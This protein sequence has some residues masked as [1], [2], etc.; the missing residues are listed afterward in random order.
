MRRKNGPVIAYVGRILPSLSETFIVREIAALRKLGL[1]IKP[2]SIHP[3]DPEVIHP[4]APE[5]SSEVEVLTCPA[6]PQ[7][8]LAHI[9][10]ALAMPHRYFSCLWKY[11]LTGERT[12]DLR[13][14]C[15]KFF[16][17]A[18]LLALRVRK[19]E[20]THIH[21]HFANVSTAVSM[22][23]AALAGISFSF[24]IHTN[25]EMIIDGI[26]MNRKLAAARF[27]VTISRFNIT[28]YLLP[29]FKATDL[30]KIHIVRCGI[31]CD[32]YI[33]ESHSQHNPPL[34][35][36]VGRLADNKGFH[37]LVSAC[38]ILKEMG[39]ETRCEIIG[40]G[41]ERANLE[42]QISE[43]GLSGAVTL[44]GQFL[45]EH[46]RNSL[47]RADLFALPCCYGKSEEEKGN[48]DGIP[49]ALMEAM[50]MGIPTISTRI[51]GIP[52][53]IL[54][55]QTG[56]L[57]SHEDPEALAHAMVRIIQDRDLAERL[58]SGGREIVEREFNIY[59]SASRLFDLF[60]RDTVRN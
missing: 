15:F 6:N 31:D 21:A 19:T 48:H 27:V 60:M 39:V 52:E 53:L 23:A 30:S 36:S 54:D 51:G 58:S 13:L 18:P 37:T 7:F 44:V 59:R 2:F 25:Y 57:V 45:A 5:L 20:V 4:E 55:E 49:V 12:W 35:L 46:V 28:H 38:R 14:R 56:L 34:I 10:F 17:L 8:W 50:A 22:M 26:L 9:F 32:K 33:P 29:L 47:S 43:A 3:F 16:L 11:V 41:P 1:A 42:E 40:E 24:T